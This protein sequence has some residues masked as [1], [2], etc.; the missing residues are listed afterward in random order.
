[1]KKIVSFLLALVLTLSLTTNALA[2]V[3][4]PKVDVTEITVDQTVDLTVTASGEDQLT[5]VVCLNYRVYFDPTFFE[6]DAAASKA[7]T[8]GAKLTALRTDE[9]GKSYYAVSLLDTASAGLTVSGD[10]YT[11]AFKVKDGAK[12]GDTSKF[13]VAKAHVY[14]IAD[15]ELK[16]VDN[17]AVENAEVTV[18]IVASTPA[19]V[20]LKEAKAALDGITV[21][22]EAA[23][24]AVSYNVLRRTA[25]TDWDVLAENVTDVT[26][27][28]E[29]AQAG[30]EYFYT[31]QGVAADGKTVSKGYDTTG[32]SARVPYPIP[33][34]VAQ[35]EAK[36]GVGSVTVT[37][38]EAENAE[39]YHVYRSVYEN[40]EDTG[41]TVIGKNVT[42]TSYQDT[43]VQSGETYYYNV[44]GVNKDGLQSNGWGAAASV[45]VP[46]PDP[47]LVE[48]VNASADLDGITVTWK[49]AANAETFS[50]YRRTADAAW[51]R[52]AEDLTGTTYTDKDVLPGTTYWYTVKGVNADGTEGSYDDNGVSATAL[53]PIPADVELTAATA[54]LD[55]ITV[56]WKTAANAASYNVL[57]KTAGAEWAVHAKN[58]M[59]TAY[60]DEDVQPGTTYWYAVQGVNADDRTSKSYDDNGVSA[61]ALYPIPADVELTAATAT[62]DGITVTWK[63]AANA[64]SYNVLRKTAGAEWTVLAN[65][66]TAAAYTDK[67]VLPGTMYWYT[68]KGVNSDGTEGGYNDNGVSATALYPIP[69]DVKMSNAVVSGN[70]IVVTWEKANGAATYNVY[71]IG[72]GDANWKIVSAK[73]SGTSY[74]DK[75][76]TAGSTYKYTVRGVA[77]D[78]KTLSP[79]FNNTGGS[80]TMPKPVTAPANV[81]LTGAKAVTGGIQVTWQAAANAATYNVYRMGPGDTCWKVV[82]VK[83]S[84]TSYT[85]K[86][87]TAGSTYKYTV[88]GVASDG[89]TLS[90]GF[91]NTGVSATMPKPVTAPANVTLTGAKAVTG[92]IQVTWQAAANAATYNVYRM[93]PGDTCWKVVSVKQSGTSYTDKN[94]T[95]GSTYKYTVRGVAADG[96]TISKGFDGTGKSATMPAAVPA[97]VK[98]SNAVVSGN[99]IV[100]TWEKANGA[101]TYNVY[102][103]GPGDTSWQAVS[104]KQSATSYTDKNVTA[105]GTYKYTVRGVAADGKTISKG[106]DG[107]GK[108]ATMPA[109]VPADVKMSNAVV[110][111]NTIVVTWEKAN[112]AATYNVYRK[113]PGD[114]SWQAVSYKQSATS[115]TDK[116]VTAG[117]TYKYTVRGVAADGKT[118]SK[119]FDGTGKSAT[120]PAAPAKVTLVSAEAD[121]AGILVKWKAATGA[122]TYNIYRKGPGDTHWKTVVYKYNGTEWKDTAVTNGV[123]YTYTVRGVAADGKTISASWDNAG[124]SDAVTKAPTTPANVTMGKVTAVKG[125][126][127]VTWSYAADAKTYN[128]YRKG[129]GDTSWQPV[130]YKQSGTSYTDKNVTAGSTYSYTVRGVSADGKTLS[131]SWD[132]GRSA[133]AK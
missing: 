41:W 94:V 42:E 115:Y 82:S 84:G 44:K 36:A 45:T 30:T 76:V 112:G 132:A 61:T 59:T 92:G 97:D 110:S 90:P 118:V 37:W 98:M 131:R 54:T 96:K 99:T 52:I 102:R 15:N 2:A 117:G 46:Y 25:D 48:V 103:K 129:P 60:T 38:A 101:A 1:M 120:M 33:A 23:D 67:D 119:G 72:P 81:T 55:G 13:T 63:T 89:K 77:S 56:T 71:R 29:T 8:E 91:N 133:V 108:S 127:T 50:V 65:N 39:S 124:K 34:N 130:A 16:A 111:G 73:Q 114:T 109:A 21:T 106:F 19:D 24:N 123:T 69:A 9:D 126:I 51:D 14:T 26:Y 85:D 66:V 5:G 75:N 53:Y 113:G 116:N 121:S 18:K 47:S 20:T 7:K 40:A 74:T 105:G 86:N 100:V 62:P 107:T 80:A 87:V 125:S 79:G 122:A 32:V 93:G 68:V 43:D 58:V 6:L 83:Q 64:A 10:L 35:V 22:W 3:V 70:T 31:V 27:K 17:G 128:I 57:R 88:R 78:G 95:A 28:D 4:S 11:L 12:L 49:T 104:Y